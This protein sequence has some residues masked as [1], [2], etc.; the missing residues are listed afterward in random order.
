MKLTEWDKLMAEY[1][2]NGGNVAND[3]HAR[4]RA[5][6]SRMSADEAYRWIRFGIEPEERDEM[7]P[8]ETLRRIRALVRLS[9]ERTLTDGSTSLTPAEADELVEAVDTLDKWIERGGF[10]PAVW[11]ASHPPF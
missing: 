9:T 11:N 5:K 10:L 1:V 4:T 2:W 8:N 6:M 7:D 3:A